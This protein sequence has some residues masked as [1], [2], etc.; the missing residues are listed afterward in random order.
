MGML[1]LIRPD[2]PAGSDRTKAPK[3]RHHWELLLVG[4]VY[5]KLVIS[6][7]ERAT[8]V[9]G[10]APGAIFNVITTL[11]V[12]TVSRPTVMLDPRPYSA[13]QLGFVMYI[14]GCL[15]R[16]GSRSER[17]DVLKEQGAA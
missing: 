16:H 15:E 7:C 9:D 1:L 11:T 2:H 14:L 10:A 13:Y 12:L 3:H 8:T 5:A 17:E 6:T 4:N